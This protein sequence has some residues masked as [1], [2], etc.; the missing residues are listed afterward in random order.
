MASLA[1]GKNKK[2]QKGGKKDQ[3][4]NKKKG[5]S[6]NN[7]RRGGN[8][9]NNNNNRSQQRS[10]GNRS[11]FYKPHETLEQ[12]HA[13][14]ASGEL[15]T[16]TLRIS[17]KKRDQA[18]VTVVG[19]PSD[20]FIDGDK[21]R[22]R[23]LNGDKIVLRLVK[24]E[25][26][27]EMSSLASLMMMDGTEDGGGG[28][29]A[30]TEEERARAAFND[31]EVQKLWNPVVPKELDFL[32]EDLKMKEKKEEEESKSKS[33]SGGGGGGGGGTTGATPAR[34]RVLDG[35]AGGLQ[36]QA[37][38]VHI[39]SRGC[40][41]EVIGLLEPFCHADKVRDFINLLFLYSQ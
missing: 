13:L 40:S 9:N 37:E 14:I 39:I 38:V 33:G 11:P 35:I 21:N 4:N 23:G 10:S 32:K 30:G 1:S 15:L 24:E 6:N 26:W 7:N 12:V 5:S 19:I 27:T 41:R 36:A 29:K 25:R 2:N 18:F 34:R 20:I 16:G 17:G 22:N 3:R 8:N 28:G 31:S